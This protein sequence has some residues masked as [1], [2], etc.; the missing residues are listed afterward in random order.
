MAPV[1]L[2]FE[3]P[4]R[5]NW[6]MFFKLRWF[7]GSLVARARWQGCIVFWASIICPSQKLQRHEILGKAV[8]TVGEPSKL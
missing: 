2:S 5:G 7:G 3:P 8:L 4:R 1:D 6:Q